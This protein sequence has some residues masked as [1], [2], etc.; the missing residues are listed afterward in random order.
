[1]EAIT[2]ITI[3]IYDWYTNKRR[4]INSMET[5]NKLIKY[6]QLFSPENRA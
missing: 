6:H 1:M 4:D 5:T 3:P 2:L